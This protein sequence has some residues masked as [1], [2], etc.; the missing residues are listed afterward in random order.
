M[1]E[2]KIPFTVDAALLRELGERLVGQSHI[3]LAEL[4]KNAYDAD[5]QKVSIRIDPD[6][7][8]ISDDGHGMTDKDIAHFWMRIGTPHKQSEGLS[9]DLQRPLTGSKGIGRLAV[10]FLARRV[11]LRTVPKKGP[12]REYR[13]SVDWDQA[14]QA[15]EL[16]KA[17]A[18]LEDKAPETDFPEGSPH[19]TS[20]ILTELNQEWDTEMI[21]GLAREIWTLQPPFRSNPELADDSQQRFEIE[22]KS[23]NQEDEDA[24]RQQLNVA[25]GFWYARLVGKAIEPASRRK[26]APNE[27]ALSLEFSDGLRK[28]LQYPIKKGHLHALD[29][30]IR[31]FHLKYKQAQGIKVNDAREYLNAFGGVHVYDA[32]FHLPY[33]GRHQDW[34]DIERDHSH[35]LSSSKLLPSE[36]QVTGGLNNLPTQ[37]RI[38][39]VVNVNTGRERS[40]A[41]R[42]KLEGR[43]EYLTIQVSRDRL[44]QNAAYHALKEAVRWAL[45]LYAMEETRRKL[46]EAEAKR[47]IEQSRK[48][49]ERIETIVSQHAAQLPQHAYEKIRQEVRA[50]VTASDAEAELN[51]R[52]M[53]LLGSLAT[54]GMTALAYEHEIGKQFHILEGVADRLSEIS[55]KDAATR[56]MLAEIREQLTQWIDQA[57]TTRMIFSHLID[58]EDRETVSRL[59]ARALL[60]QVKRQTT[61]LTR[62]VDIDISGV[63]PELR[64]PKGTFAEW[65]AIFQ[66]VLVNAANAMLESKMRRIS[67]RSRVRARSRAIRIL[68]TG[69]GVDLQSAEELF[70]PFVRKL[71]LSPERSAMGL[72]GMGLGLAIVRMLATNLGCE[73]AF[74]EPDEGFKTSFEI[75][76]SE[77]E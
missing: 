63:D 71:Q 12:Q 75:E 35:R 2:R 49:L 42:R 48:K 20:I 51:Q 13:V 28:S 64:L 72:G 9:R 70:E 37:S 21:K 6:R 5:A 4:V 25:L 40:E 57:R 60:D 39:G 10:Q 44:V 56:K 65:S 67:I 34:L 36:L 46:A 29:F 33:Y 14:V 27:V 47:P 16:T 38:F 52:K 45:D 18:L 53:G 73:V 11:E 19:G 61:V 31:I 62:G 8:E 58:A 50:A 17:V 32:G 3:A 69:C 7:I 77:Q 15:G 68:D 59:R 41:A 43:G 30:E 54:A 55:T 24:F 66:N 26:D 1:S 23:S 22:L 76:W 74:V